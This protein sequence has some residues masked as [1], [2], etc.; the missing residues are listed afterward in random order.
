MRLRHTP[1]A[2]SETLYHVVWSPKDRRDVWQGEGPQ[3][4]QELLADLAEPYD[5]P[6]EE[7]EGRPDH[8]P[9]L[10]SFPPRYALAHVVTR[11]KRLRARAIFRECPRVKRRLWGGALWEDGWRATITR[12]TSRMRSSTGSS[13][14]CRPRA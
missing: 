9:I 12:F 7:L 2:V 14:G 8:G 13:G 1:H 5:S 4:G 11:F 3:R 6:M 10:C